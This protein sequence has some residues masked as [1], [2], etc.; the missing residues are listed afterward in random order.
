MPVLALPFPMIDPIALELGPLAIRWYGLA[1][2]TG[3][4]LGWYYARKLAANAALWGGRPAPMT[5]LDTISF[6]LR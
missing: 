2:L 1:Y 6:I 5:P 4:L 3:I